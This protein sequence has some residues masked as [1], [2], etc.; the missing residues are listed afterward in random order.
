MEIAS[1]PC[2]SN[3]LA[4]S[5]ESG[6]ATQKMPQVGGKLPRSRSICDGGVFFI[7]PHLPAPRTV[8]HEIEAKPAPC[9]E[10]G[11]PRKLYW[12]AGKLPA[13]PPSERSEV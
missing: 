6:F 8:D 12:G 9:G 5:G 2:G 10:Q 13:Q 3:N 1:N 11:N 4:F 7:Q